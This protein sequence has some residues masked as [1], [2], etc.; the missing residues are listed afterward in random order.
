MAIIS[1]PSSPYI[2]QQYTATNNLSYI[3]DG[4]K[5]ASM[6]SLF[7]GGTNYILPAASNSI[8]GGVKIGSNI[9]VDGSG[10]ISVS[11]QVQSD[12]TQTN[13]VA[14]DYIKNKPN[15][16]AAQIQSD[17]NVSDNTLKSYIVNKPNVPQLPTNAAG[18]L[19]NSGNGTLSWEPVISLSSLKS[20]VASSTSFADFQ[21]R[22]AAL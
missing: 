18:Y 7:G 15:I 1:F 20:L 22:I 11:A 9:T 16:P 5:W 4:E 12:W 19:Y 21:S 3:W 8:L 17:W 14:L 6:A 10:V 13:A 2:G